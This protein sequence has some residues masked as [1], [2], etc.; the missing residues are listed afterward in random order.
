MVEDSTDWS[1]PS[2]AELQKLY[3]NQIAIGGFSTDVYWA[4]KYFD[5]GFGYLA[6]TIDFGTGANTWGQPFNQI[7]WGASVRAV[8]YF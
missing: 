8:R 6:G 2:V 5:G 3:D 1:L 7:E 4:S